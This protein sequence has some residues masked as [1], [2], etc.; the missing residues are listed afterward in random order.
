MHVGNNHS[1]NVLT[2]IIIRASIS[3]DPDCRE[4]GQSSSG[5]AMKKKARAESPGRGARES[6]DRTTSQRQPWVLGTERALVRKL[7]FFFF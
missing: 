2:V 1:T 6:E 3:G 4:E 7:R 5:W